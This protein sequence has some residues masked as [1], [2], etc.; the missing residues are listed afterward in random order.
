[1]SE[2]DVRLLAEN[3]LKRFFVFTFVESYPEGVSPQSNERNI[4]RKRF[5]KG[6][7]K[8]YCFI[9][10]KLQTSRNPFTLFT[11]IVLIIFSSIGLALVREGLAKKH[12]S[13]K[14]GAKEGC[15]VHLSRFLQR[16]FIQLSGHSSR[17]LRVRDRF[18]TSNS[19]YLDA[20]NV[21]TVGSVR[22]RP[23]A[24]PTPVP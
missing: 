6:C 1:V 2:C 11:V 4:H 23:A 10:V 15:S 22:D 24:A 20:V 9:K 13:I 7:H 16:I 21:H 3:I 8:V 18:V 5:E 19:P 14:L 17:C 12:F